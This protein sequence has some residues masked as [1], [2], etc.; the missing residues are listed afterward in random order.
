MDR[1]FNAEEFLDKLSQG[2]FDGRLTD[3]FRKLSD[4]QREQVALLMAKRLKEEKPAKNH[5]ALQ[6]Q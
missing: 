2:A 4:E 6:H 1:I 5:T 3:E